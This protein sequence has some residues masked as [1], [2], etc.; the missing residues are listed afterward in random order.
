L[1]TKTTNL[2]VQNYS[3]DDY[4]QAFWKAGLHV[5]MRPFMLNDFIKIKPENA[6]FPKASDSLYYHT[7]VKTII[8]ARK[9]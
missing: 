2:P 7:F 6:Y 4:A 1:I 3:L 5:S 8:E 9:S